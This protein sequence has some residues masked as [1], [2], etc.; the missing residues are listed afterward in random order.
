MRNPRGATPETEQHQLEVLRSRMRGPSPTR[1]SRARAARRGALWALLVILMGTA[2]GAAPWRPA[3]G[4][5]GARP[6]VGEDAETQQDAEILTLAA[7]RGPARRLSPPAVLVGLL[8]QEADSILWEVTWQPGPIQ[9]SPP[10]GWEWEAD[11]SYTDSVG[12]TGVTNGGGELGP[13]ARSARFRSVRACGDTI[14]IHARVRALGSWRVQGE[15][16]TET[17]WGQV[18]RMHFRPCEDPPPGPPT[19]GVDTAAVDTVPPDPAPIEAYYIEGQ[20]VEWGQVSAGSGAPAKYAVRHGCPVVL[21]DEAEDTEQI[22]DLGGDADVGNM[23]QLPIDPPGETCQYQLRAFEGLP[24]TDTYVQGLSSR[25]VDVDLRTDL[26]VASLECWRAGSSVTWRSAL[27]VP[28]RETADPEHLAPRPSGWRD[29][30]SLVEGADVVVSVETESWPEPPYG[31]QTLD[32]F[33][34]I[35]GPGDDWSVLYE[36]DVGDVVA[37]RDEENNTRMV[38]CP[39]TADSQPPG[40]LPG[41]M[42]GESP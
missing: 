11:W 26:R 25:E 4:M 32:P 28:W 40:P 24:G 21:W 12:F 33:P 14:W 3:V 13:E 22:V 42:A 8:A 37:E 17:G 19:V 5:A 29:R 15:T 39:Q 41:D 34:A 36:A 27:E 16:I 10:T 1:R 7:Q 31:H 38:A 35:E 2:C 6:E 30:V 18:R 23:A 20:V 9:G